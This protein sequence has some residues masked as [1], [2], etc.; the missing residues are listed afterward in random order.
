M[1][2]ILKDYFYTGISFSSFFI[3]EGVFLCLKVEKSK[4]PLIRYF[5]VLKLRKYLK[6]HP[7][8]DECLIGNEKY[9]VYQN[10]AAFN[11]ASILFS[12]NKKHKQ[13]YNK[14]KKD[15]N[16][17]ICDKF[18]I[19]DLT[20]ESLEEPIT[21]VI[22][23]E[24]SKEKYKELISQAKEINYIYLDKIKE[25]TNRD[26]IFDAIK[27]KVLQYE[28]NIFFIEEGMY[29][30]YIANSIFNLNKIAIIY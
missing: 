19:D 25:E 20:K 11:N 1:N 5:N 14:L 17:L 27:V 9:L 6:N 8:T 23:N 10:V 21:L 3:D 7:D 16:T 13:I 24:D 18:D 2:E 22:K 28:T 4:N 29:A 15:R 26:I 30:N 12:Q